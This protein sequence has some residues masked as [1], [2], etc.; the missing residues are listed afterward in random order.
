MLDMVAGAG[1]LIL[2]VMWAVLDG[3]APRLYQGGFVIAGIAAAL[4]IATAA[5][6]RRG[7]IGWV[8]SFPP[9]CWLGLISYG[10]YLW[11]W[12]VDIVLDADRVGLTGWPLFALRSTV[13]LSISVASYFL[14]ELPIRRG[15]LRPAQWRIAIPVVT[16]ALLGAIVVTTAGAVEPPN[17]NTAA[18]APGAG[19][20][21]LLLGDSVANSLTPGFTNEHIRV[22]VVWTPGCRVIHGDLRFKNE[23]SA[24]CDWEEP[25][26]R[27]VKA[28]SPKRIVVLIGVWDLFDVRPLGTNTFLAPGTPAWAAVYAAQ[29]ERMIQI[30]GSRGAQVTLLAIPCSGTSSFSPN[31]FREGGFDINRVNA[32]NEVMRR[33]A[34]HHPGN[35]KFEDLF[36]LL[37]PFGKYTGVIKGA[38]VRTDGVHLSRAGADLVAQWLLPRIGLSPRAKRTPTTSTTAGKPRP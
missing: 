13:A 36:G 11:H 5:H 29:L 33:V 34:S 21:L 1:V 8:L 25:W 35:V 4:V 24:N 19:K 10:L 37:C 38:A 6:P 22:G 15:A 23:F 30:L 31:Q 9:L 18:Y 17:T 26:G 2:A 12:P 3:K 28:T 32:A 27:A 7:P 20:D 14:V 16:A